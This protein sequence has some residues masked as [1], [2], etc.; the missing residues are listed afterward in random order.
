MLKRESYRSAHSPF[1]SVT[2]L[3]D[4]EFD[5]I[6]NES[7]AHNINQPKYNGSRSACSM[8]DVIS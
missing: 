6:M 7:W 4:S 8:A 3:L 1:S 2:P 5:D